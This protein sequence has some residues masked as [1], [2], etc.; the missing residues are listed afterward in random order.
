MIGHATEKRRSCIA[1]K[2]KHDNNNEPSPGRAKS[3]YLTLKCSFSSKTFWYH[4][5]SL[6][7]DKERIADGTVTTVASIGVRRDSYLD[8]RV[9][10]TALNHNLNVSIARANALFRA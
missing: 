6:A 7:S 3:F 10:D 2:T 1:N 9:L 8:R 4:P 5:F